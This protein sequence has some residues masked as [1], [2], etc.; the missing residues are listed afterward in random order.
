M[1]KRNGVY[2]LSDRSF[3]ASIEGSDAPDRR[4]LS[5]VSQNQEEN[6]EPRGDSEDEWDDLYENPVC[7]LILLFVGIYLTRAYKLIGL[8]QS[9]SQDVSILHRPTGCKSLEYFIV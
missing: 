3:E 4:C 1:M 7:N 5:S 2:F 8:Y 6:S 9:V